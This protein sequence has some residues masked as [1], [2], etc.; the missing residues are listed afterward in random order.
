MRAIILTIIAL[1]LLLILVSFDKG[2]APTAPESKQQQPASGP[3][4]LT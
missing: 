3:R 4:T 2:P 1:L